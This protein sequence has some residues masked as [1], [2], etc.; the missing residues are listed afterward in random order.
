MD[1]KPL[2][3]RPKQGTVR[4]KQDTIS[5]EGGEWY[6]PDVLNVINLPNALAQVQ[7]PE[8]A[9]KFVET[10]GPLLHEYEH[11]ENAPSSE[12]LPLL[13]SH[14]SAVRFS[15]RLLEALQDE[16]DERIA[17]IL[18]SAK[19]IRDNAP[20]YGPGNFVRSFVLPEGNLQN[21]VTLNAPYRAE[22]VEPWRELAVTVVCYVANQNTIL[23]QPWLSPEGTHFERKVTGYKVLTLAQLVWFGVGEI[24]LLGQQNKK[25]RRIR[26]CE[27]CGTPFYALDARQRFCP[28][29]PWTS[30]SRCAGRRQQRLIRAR[31]KKEG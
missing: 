19:V 6:S 4:V 28:P 14:A 21:T 17:R 9:A 8:A 11:T 30:E 31:R 15:L 27:E 12:S 10:Y 7:S 26:L 16:D 5:F 25:Q 13:L 3:M 18:E 24:A 23:L 1:A 22:G 29:D 2:F 20:D